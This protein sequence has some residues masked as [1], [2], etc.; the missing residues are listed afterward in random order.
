MTG[1]VNAM[2]IGMTTGL[3]YGTIFGV[4]Y[5]EDLFQST[6]LG[7]LAG[8]VSGLIIGMT[9]N[10]L[11]VIEGVLSGVMGGMMGAMLGVMLSPQH[12][13]VAVKLMFFLFVFVIFSIFYMLQNDVIKSKSSLLTT[14]IIPLTILVLIFVIFERTEPML[15][16][17]EPL[18]HPSSHNMEDSH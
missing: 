11:A 10:M 1:M 18:E 17:D 15:I 3:T 14:P 7:L 4:I 6:V 2:A 13:S 12:Q 8:M 5:S 9:I 16:K